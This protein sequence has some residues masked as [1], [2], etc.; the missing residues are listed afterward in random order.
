MDSLIVRRWV[1]VHSV[2]GRLVGDTG[3]P[4]Q[5][6]SDRG[7]ATTAQT[8]TEDCRAR[9]SVTQIAC[10][11]C[12]LLQPNGTRKF[13]GKPGECRE[14]RGLG[15][16]EQEERMPGCSGGHFGLECPLY[17]DTGEGGWR[18]GF[19]GGSGPVN[20]AADEALKRSEKLYKTADGAI[21]AAARLVRREK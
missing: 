1:I 15:Y 19:C 11:A 9:G 20:K 6:F 18:C 10:G 14:C 8:Q 17:I 3:K 7:A 12:T 5:V 4:R 2:H 21:A 16:F 13:V